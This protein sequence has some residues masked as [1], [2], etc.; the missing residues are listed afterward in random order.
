M[1]QKL[2]YK[3]RKRKVHKGTRGGHYVIYNK[4]KRHISIQDA[5][6]FS[7]IQKEL[8]YEHNLRCVYISICIQSN[9]INTTWMHRSIPSKLI[10]S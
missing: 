1:I 4:K 2:L 9:K 3:G 5:F 7:S 6:L 10:A 8:F